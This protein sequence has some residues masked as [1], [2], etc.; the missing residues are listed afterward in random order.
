MLGAIQS[1]S[2][3]PG[4]AGRGKKCHIALRKRKRGR[5]MWWRREKSDKLEGASLVL[6]RALWTHAQAPDLS[7][8]KL[9]NGPVNHMQRREE[10]YAGL[11]QF[12]SP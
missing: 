2:A 1:D 9:P 12:M 6:A 7:Q 3:G 5:Q 11:C 8:A 10:A 4:E